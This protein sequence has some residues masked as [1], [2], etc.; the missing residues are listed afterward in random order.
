[1]NTPNA[2][3]PTGAVL[4][5]FDNYNDTRISGS[6]FAASRVNISPV[7]VKNSVKCITTPPS[8]LNFQVGEYVVEVE[9]LYNARG[10][11][12]AYQGVNRET[13]FENIIGIQYDGRN[14]PPGGGSTFTCTIPGA[15]VVP[16]RYNNSAR[17]NTTIENICKSSS[18]SYDF[19]ATDPD[20]DSLVYYFA[21]AY[22]GDKAVDL[23][24]SP[25]ANPPYKSVNYKSGYS[26]TAPLGIYARI[27]SRTGLITGTAPPFTGNY[28]VGV[29]IYEFRHDTLLSFHRKDITIIVSSCTIIEAALQKTYLNCKDYTFYFSNLVFPPGILTY[30]WYF[31]DGNHSTASEPIYT[32]GSS[33]TYTLKLI[34]NKGLACE[35]S[36]IAEV[37]VYPG[38]TPD[39]EALGTCKDFPVQF[40]DKSTAAYGVINKWTWDFGDGGTAIFQNPT[41]TY[42]VAKDYT[43]MLAVTSSVGC[44]AT[45]TKILRIDNKPAFI[46]S[47]KDTLICNVDTL[48]IAAIGTG[49]AVWSPNYN[50]S[51]V[52]SQNPLVSPDITTIYKVSL[53]DAFGCRGID[54]IKVRVVDRV[55]QSGDYDTTICRTDTIKLRLSSD[56]IYFTWTPNDG[57]LNNTLVKHPMAYP[58]V[59][60]TYK[61]VGKI[62]NKCYAEN[63]ITVKPI[64]YPNAIV[65]D[66]SICLGQSAQLHASGGSIYNWSPNIFLSNANIPDPL[67]IKPTS[68]VKYK[69]TVRDILGCPK[70][71]QKIVTLHVIQIKADAGPRDTAVVLGQPLQLNATGGND[72]VWLSNNS[73]LSNIQ[74]NNP[75][76]FPLDDIEYIVKVTNATGCFA[77]DSISIKLYKLVPGI[78][79][80][81][82]F[83]PNGDSRNDYFKPIGLGIR[84]LDLFRVY[85]RVGQLVYNSTDLRRGW[86]GSFGGQ[87]LD[88]GT[89]VWVA[90]GTDYNNKKIKRSGTVILIR[91]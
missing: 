91:L 82:A 38:F 6:P 15:I 21:E 32:Y 16:G 7:P 89:F 26:G 75:V 60:T 88:P 40:N 57:S 10:Y 11:T 30:D 59:N 54:S 24:S 67:V 62:S 36:A 18:L 42:S 83:T 86:D 48:R 81:N 5:I 85:N 77:Y 45:S 31:G 41:H 27:D 44:W 1:M 49:T 33:G 66:V 35:D 55:T 3:M 90:E 9:L 2:E 70:P 78:Y 17:F 63:S 80:P 84:S 29:I 76:A 28:V 73:W 72:Y 71:V 58:L 25:P 47:P 51:D 53:T 12:V 79:V 23:Y 65:D 34:I 4:G 13:S 14:S 68:G 8:A 39:F 56:A 87:K 50:I 20:G 43:V 22:N 46:M 69:L 61:V 52:N 19:S 64:P 74:I 37:K